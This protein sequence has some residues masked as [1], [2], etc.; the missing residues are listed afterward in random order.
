MDYID[1]HTHSHF[2][3]GSMSPTDLVAL[4]KHCSLR[5]IALTDH[6]TVDGVAEAIEAAKKYGIEVIPGIEFSAVSTGETH[7]LG[8][9]IDIY[10]SELVAAI[11]LAKELR[12]QNNQRTAEALQ[13]L[14]FDITVEDA[15]KL[16]PIGNLGRAHFAKVMENKGY[17]NSVKEAFD[18]YLQKG[19]PAFNSL[20][21]LQPE[22]AVKLIK[23]AG[24]KAYLA[25]LHLT[26]M[27]DKEL[28]AYVVSL[29]NAGLDGL[30]GYYTEYDDKMQEEYQA[31]AQKYGLKISG[32]TDFHGA[33]KPH[34]KLGV[35]YGNLKIP[36]NLIKEMF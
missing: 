36:Y 12:L 34:I 1:L 30:E 7:I 17:V 23:N 2:S 18:L 21:L 33:N 32:G 4:A 16:S 3:D 6:D 26:K 35:G 8:Y 24:G 14:G 25:H 9:G 15:R 11:D 27:K 22:D 5:A 19:R 10:N 29:K 13:K 28:E 20:R 31:L